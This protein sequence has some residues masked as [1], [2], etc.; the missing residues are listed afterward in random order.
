MKT[1]DLF[2]KSYK[3][4]FWLLLI[5]L[6]TIKRNV[7]GYNKIILL[8]PESEKHDFETR[9]LPDRTEIFY[10][11]DKSP[12]WLMQQVFKMSA[13]KYSS[14]DF[15][16]FSDSDN[17]FDHPLDLQELVKDDRPEILYTDWSLVGD[18]IVWREPTSRFLKRDIEWEM[19][20]RLCLIYHRD[21]L[22]NLYNFEPDAEKII[23]ASNKFSEF[24]TISAF[25]YYNEPEKY[26]FK[27]TA[28]WEYTEPHSLQVW[29]HSN[30]NSDSILHLKEYIRVLESIM[31]C[32]DVPVPNQ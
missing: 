30:K 29:S 10:V 28:D 5:S 21:T 8:I 12:G 3:P 11:E 27:N 15:I 19:M 14:A 32:F 22:V 9:Y 7:K 2:V 17:F 31:K 20:R 4:D 13:H 26:K 24:N 16:M 25:A 1:I 18:A 6:E 23:M